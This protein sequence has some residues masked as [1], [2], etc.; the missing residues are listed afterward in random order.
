[1]NHFHRLFIWILLTVSFC[2]CGQGQT[3][4][5]PDGIPLAEDTISSEILGVINNGG[6]TINRDIDL[7]GHKCIVPP[8]V[9]ITFNG[10]VIKNGTLVGN[11]TKLMGR[12]P[13]FEKVR[14]IGAWDVPIIKTTIFKD[15]SYDNSLKDVVALSNPSIENEI[16]IAEGEYFV[17]ANENNDA[18]IPISSNT[19]L[20]ADGEIRIKPN[21]L[22]SY[23]II[24]VKGNNVVIKGNGVII[25]DKHTH[26]G[27]TG[28]WGM[29]IRL[30]NAHNILIEGLA[31]KEC[32]GDCIY[33]GKKSS[34]ITIKKCKLDHGRR[35]GISITSASDVYISNCSITNVSGTAPEFAIDVEPNKNDT[36]NKV[37]INNVIIENCIGGIAATGKAINSKV[38]RINLLNNHITAKGKYAV[39]MVRCE[40]VIIKDNQIKQSEGRK[41]LICKEIE[42]LQVQHNSLQNDQSLGGRIKSLF[43]GAEDS[44]YKDV[45]RIVD[46]KRIVDR[47]NILK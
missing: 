25:G 17:S 13:Y 7:G 11:N 10:G 46:C 6:I 31:I 30:S 32:W 27:D 38:S 34:N 5:W 40:N 33:V 19:K 28:E 26:T 44:R 15:L 23:N 14:I 1:M 22:N 47:N 24:Q 9:T 35:Q 2:S 42:S 37:Y 39:K 21:N 4:V 29:G 18:C 12:K 3:V 16:I 41:V 45:V 43:K 36:I 20:T 8:Y